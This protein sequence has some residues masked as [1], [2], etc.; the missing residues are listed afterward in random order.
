MAWPACG[1]GCARFLPRHAPQD[2]CSLSSSGGSNPPLVCLLSGLSGGDAP[3]RIP[4][5]A[6]RSWIYHGFSDCSRA[7]AWD[8]AA[9]HSVLEPGLQLTWI[10]WTQDLKDFAR[11]SGCD[12]VY[13]E[14]GRNAN[15]EG[16]VTLSTCP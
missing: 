14:T 4:P 16:L 13:S 6:G 5:R 10:I 11:Q 3:A 15:G 9:Q 2:D 12:V 8:S 1:I 7:C